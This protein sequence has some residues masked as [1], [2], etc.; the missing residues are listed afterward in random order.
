M[1]SDD[2]ESSQGQYSR[3][4]GASHTFEEGEQL[5][6]RDA[7]PL[8]PKAAFFMGDLRDGLPMVR[9][10]VHTNLSCREQEGSSRVHL[11]C[12]L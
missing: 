3:T 7:R 4:H 10:C 8:L 1:M 11:D 9:M 2:N 5:G 6:A 12:Y